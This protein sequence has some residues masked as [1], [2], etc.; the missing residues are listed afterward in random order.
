MRHQTNYV[1]IN[2]YCSN[3]TIPYRHNIIYFLIFLC[4]REIIKSSQLPCGID[5]GQ[6][7]KMYSS[8]PCWCCLV[9]VIAYTN[10][11][12]N[13]QTIDALI[14]NVTQPKSGLGSTNQDASGRL[15]LEQKLTDPEKN[16]SVLWVLFEDV[17][18]QQEQLKSTVATQAQEIGQLSRALLDCNTNY[19]I[20]NESV[21]MCQASIDLERL[22]IGTLDHRIDALQRQHVRGN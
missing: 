8:Y 19:D 2:R 17:V 14:K 1:Q 22:R 16:N 3:Q 21:T 10:C 5:L 6:H 18:K 13:D 12:S 20:L 15:R 4:R 9:M 11:E 7:C